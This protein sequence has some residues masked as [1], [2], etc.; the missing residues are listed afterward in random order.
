MTKWLTL[1]EF[2]E[3]FLMKPKNPAL[4]RGTRIS[5]ISL[6]DKQVVRSVFRSIGHTSPT[7]PDLRDKMFR[8]IAKSTKLQ[9]V[10]LKALSRNFTAQKDILQEL[11]RKPQLRGRFFVLAQD[12]GT[13]SKKSNSQK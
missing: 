6:D 9:H 3:E 8:E 5:V 12:T 10:I 4:D 2:E 7:N 13:P 11:I 1:L